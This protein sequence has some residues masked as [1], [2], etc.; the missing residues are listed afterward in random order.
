[1]FGLADKIPVSHTGMHGFEFK[2]PFPVPTSCHRRQQ[3]L[4][5]QAVEHLPL[6]QQ[7]QTEF[8]TLDFGSWLQFWSS[9]CYCWH[10]RMGNLSLSLS[11]CLLNNSLL[12]QMLSEQGCLPCLC[13]TGRQQ[14]GAGM[15][16]P[17]R[18]MENWL[19]ILSLPLTTCSLSAPNQP[20]Q[21]GHE[22][23]ENSQKAD[24]G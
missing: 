3:G 7:T 12:I 19:W 4:K 22:R 21:R 10:L 5:I 20:P 15:T 11:L 13:L 14:E 17:K 18:S 23:E 2:C 9:S 16:L 6:T 8:P 1:M 24:K